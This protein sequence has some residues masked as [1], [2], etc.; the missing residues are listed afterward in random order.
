[1]SFRKS[2]A[3]TVIVSVL[4]AGVAWAQVSPAPKKARP[5]RNSSPRVPTQR[6]THSPEFGGVSIHYQRISAAQFMSD[7]G[8]DSSTSTWNP[9]T[10]TAYQRFFDAPGFNHLVSSPTLPGGA[11]I[12]YVELDACD[13]SVAGEHVTLDVYDCD[14]DGVCVS[15][16]LSTL[17]TV[18]NVANPCAFYTDD[19]ISQRVD[20]F[21]GQTL[22]DV[23]MEATDGTNTLAGV[24]IGYVLEVS[25]APGTPT[26]NDVPDT[27]PFFQFIE[28][29]ADA[30]V[31]GGC[32]AVP[33]L[34]CPDNPVTRGQMAVF[35]SKLTG[36]S[37]SGF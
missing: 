9:P 33:P 21:A 37:W 8:L 1:M 29:L 13:D 32:N 17:T 15:T 12:V 36:L 31:T 10:A 18:S 28:A 25:P 26:F 3:A 16:P 11:R 34:Y 5:L 6:P 35:M 2:F 30:G 7:V 14:F 27:H 20:N 23:S 4:A 19:A 24:V 22:L